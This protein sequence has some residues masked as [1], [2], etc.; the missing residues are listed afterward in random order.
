MHGTETMQWLQKGQRRGTSMNSAIQV[1]PQDQP[2]ESM[3]GRRLFSPGTIAAYTVVC[4]LPLG[5]ILYGLNLRARHQ[6]LIGAV[7]FWLG[8]VSLVLILLRE[9]LPTSVVP[10]SSGLP[11]G[12]HLIIK[13]LVAIAIYKLEKGP[14]ERGLLRGAVRARWWAPAL[15]GLAGLGLLYATTWFGI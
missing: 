3:V 11:L 14:F 4:N 13:T 12:L 2:E 8:I 6:T 5:C 7:F 15:W 1:S 10:P 9:V